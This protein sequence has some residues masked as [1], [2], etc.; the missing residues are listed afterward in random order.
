VPPSD[1]SSDD[2]LE[3]RH[4]SRPR[5]GSLGARIVV[6]A[7]APGE[8]EERIGRPLVGPSGQ[9]LDQWWARV[10]L[11]REMM[12]LENVV[13]ERPPHNQINTLTKEALAGWVAD[14]HKRLALLRDPW[15]IVA[16]GNVSLTAL[17]GRVGITKWRGSILT[18]TLADGRTIKCVPTIHPAAT[19]R[20]PYYAK[21]C[22]KDWERIAVEAQSRENVLPIRTHITRPTLKQVEEYADAA[23]AS[24]APLSIDIE[25]PHYMIG[26]VGFSYDPNVSLTVPTLDAVALC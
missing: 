4:A 7:E 21:R 12:R 22:V 24:G 14:L 6:V 17:T 8:Y 5:V 3:R 26:C 23:I 11:G 19:F 9:L 16:V 20:E 13:E 10:G 18:T 25:T 1:D 15:V 2:E